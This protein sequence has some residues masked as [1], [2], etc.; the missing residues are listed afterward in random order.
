M[1]WLKDIL[2]ISRRNAEIFRLTREVNRAHRYIQEIKDTNQQTHE[3][4]QL[5]LKNSTDCIEL[6]EKV[7]RLHQVGVDIEVPPRGRSWAVVCITG[8]VD[9][10]GFVDL[11]ERDA[12]QIKHFFEQYED[13][14]VDSPFSFIK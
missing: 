12:R 4:A 7:R 13:P 9:R 8:R 5:A 14:T 1:K 3:R 6:V 11:S 10:V 2:G